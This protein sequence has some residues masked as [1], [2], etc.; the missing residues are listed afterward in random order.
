[1]NDFNDI[2]NDWKSVSSTEIE[3]NSESDSLFAKLKKLQR[4]I[5]FGNLFMSISFAAVFAVFIWLWNANLGKE[6]SDNFYMGLT[7]MFVLLSITLVMMWYRV[8]FWRTPNDISENMKAF[9][10][11]M[12]KKLR[13]FKWITSFFMPTYLV[14]LAVG[15]TIY[16]QDVLQETSL[17][18][19]LIAYG[20]TYVWLFVVGF[21]MVR[22]KRKKNNKDVDPIIENLEEVLDTLA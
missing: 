20:A 6:R 18:I 19:K 9:A 10:T 17:T 7:F 1:M 16:Y 4:K 15:I 3:V 14:L 11:K 21:I 8:L 12:L 5:V 13:Y 22:K 2:L